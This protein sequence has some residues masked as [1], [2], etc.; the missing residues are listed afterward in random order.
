MENVKYIYIYI[1][2]YISS[3][4]GTDITNYACDIFRVKSCNIESIVLKVLK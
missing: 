4:L 3:V 2:I 1:Y